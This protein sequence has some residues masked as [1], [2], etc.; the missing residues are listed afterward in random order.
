[1]RISAARL[2][3]GQ[4]LPG[5]SLALKD[6]VVIVGAVFAG[7]N[8][9]HIGPFGNEFTG[10]EVNAQAVSS[11]V[12]GC[13]LQR[14]N[15][16]AEGAITALFVLWASLFALKLRFRTGLMVATATMVSWLAASQL[17]FNS[18][19]L[20]LPVSGPSI[21]V[22]LPFALIH[23]VRA[24][25][26]YQKR[27]EIQRVFGQYVSDQV[28]DHLLLSPSNRELSGS[29]GNASVLFFDLRSSVEFAAGRD[30]K[31]IMEELNALFALIVPRVQTENGLLLRYT[32]DG[33]LAVFGVPAPLEDHADGALRTAQGIVETL[34]TENRSRVA[35]GK[36]AWKFGCG[37]H[38]GPLAF[39]NLG[40]ARRPEFTVI[41]D[42][43][44]LAARLQETC[45]E[46]GAEVAISESTYRLAGAPAARGPYRCAIRGYLAEVTVYT[47]EAPT[48]HDSFGDAKLL[49][50]TIST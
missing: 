22:L 35:E 15:A 23:T 2:A 26:D 48:E 39:G 6:A 11:V 5:E 20:A 28:R 29:V 16:L 31:E 32:G 49:V 42:T 46:L 13:V 1:M 8:D 44:N 27:V 4:L 43:V 36:P 12:D 37:V 47:L 24:V 10:P 7:S 50:G 18:A 3:A 19:M 25:G 38:S 34:H 17:A 14:F 21:G 30:P 41:G 9:F 45:K 40:T 33:F